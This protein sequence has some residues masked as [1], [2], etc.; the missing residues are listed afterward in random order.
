[1]AIAADLHARLRQL[2]VAEDRRDSDTAFALRAA[3]IADRLADR[4]KHPAAHPEQLDVALCDRHAADLERRGRHDEAL[5]LLTVARVD[6]SRIGDSLWYARVLVHAVAPCVALLDFANAG[7]VL[8]SL[9]RL[10]N[11]ADLALDRA[12]DAAYRLDF[13]P[14]HAVIAVE[15]ADLH[16]LRVE[17]L[18]GLARWRAAVGKLSSASQ[19]LEMALALLDE[20]PSRWTAREEVEIFAAEV[21]L[22]RGALEAFDALRTGRR[23]GRKSVASTVDAK[24]RMLEGTARHLQGRF[25]EAETCFREAISYFTSLAPTSAYVESARWQRA[26]ALAALNR[27]DEAEAECRALAATTD[28]AD[29]SVDVATLVRILAARRSAASVEL[30]APPAPRE[31]ILGTGESE[32]PPDASSQSTTDDDRLTIARRCE[33]VRDELARLCWEVLLNLHRGAVDLATLR[34]DSLEYWCRDLDSPLLHAR[35][36]R[37]AALVAYYRQ[38]FQRAASFAETAIN[39]YKTLDLTADELDATRVY[40]WSLRASGASTST[41]TTAIRRIEELMRVV[42]A[43]LTFADRVFFKLN[44]WSVVDDAIGAKCRA[45][46]VTTNLSRRRRA[47][48]V[49]RLLSDILAA[50]RWEME[51]GAEDAL[52]TDTLAEPVVGDVFSVAA[53]HL[54]LRYRGTTR[55][56]ETTQLTSAWLPRDTGVLV[57][58]SLPDRLELFLIHRGGS[59]AI[60]ISRRVS[61]IDVFHSIASCVASLAEERGLWHPGLANLRV[62]AE[63]LGLDVLAERLPPPI[64]RLIVVPDHA[65]VHAPFAAL[66]FRGAPLVNSLSVAFA[67]TPRWDHRRA[68][69]PP[70]GPAVVVDTLGIEWPEFGAGSPTGSMH[71]AAGL[72]EITGG[73]P[74]RLMG[75]TATVAAV[76]RA[77][78]AAAIAHFACHADFNPADPLASGILL[79]DGWFSVRDI[80]RLTLDRVAIVVLGSCWGANVSVLAGREMIGLPAALLARGAQTVVA[81][82]WELADAARGEQSPTVTFLR[83]FYAELSTRPIYAALA[84]V[85]SEWAMM[86]PVRDWAA[87]HAFARGITP[88]PL[89]RAGLAIVNRLSRA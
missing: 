31:V 10:P 14:S 37:L 86:H 27:M 29:E 5:R 79:T 25:S 4:A 6:A 53:E 52:P 88:R 48:K 46:H 34:L 58:V 77:L 13:P 55:L 38:D 43:R 44:K 83:D 71:E 59:E 17:A 1:M 85:Q 2:Q 47:K 61:R 76:K 11:D 30:D 3:L 24:W 64:R 63:M 20:A 8:R 35:V 9:L 45:L 60:D 15:A 56:Q 68:V 73:T 74:L 40:L 50:K 81:A 28:V 19:A 57:Y 89:V 36:S 78:P 39:R 7:A 18:T 42:T 21:L 70:I 22:D 23:E 16:A 75:D 49:E 82:L 80:D 87:Y 41:I 26:Q 51:G 33:R 65:I 32:L 84:H 12:T 72:A 69:R 66:P 67:P 62:L 54:R